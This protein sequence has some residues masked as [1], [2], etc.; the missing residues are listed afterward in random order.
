[1]SDVAHL[2]AVARKMISQHGDRA[3]TLADARSLENFKAGDHDAGAYWQKVGR[4]VRELHAVGLRK[5]NSVHA[6]LFRKAF[7][8]TPHPYALLTPSMKIVGANAAY[9]T[10]TM[11]RQTELLGRDIFE[12]FP[13]N[14]ETPEA[15][16]VCN[17]RKS[18]ARVLGSNCPDIMPLQRHDICRPDRIFQERWWELINIPIFGDDG[19]LIMLMHCATDVT[20][21]VLRDRTAA[22]GQCG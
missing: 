3:A 19:D 20:G 6:N 18:F 11:T 8:A 13:D 17:L 9:L 4:V 15:N 22:V 2:V 10:A 14:P 16:G 7:E 21:R 1:M 12:V 5:A